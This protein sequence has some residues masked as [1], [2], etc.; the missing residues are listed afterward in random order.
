M[1]AVTRNASSVPWRPVHRKRC[2]ERYPLKP[3]K[4]LRRYDVATAAGP[5]LYTLGC[6]NIDP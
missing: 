2:L 3:S 6:D 1:E 5:T 4:H